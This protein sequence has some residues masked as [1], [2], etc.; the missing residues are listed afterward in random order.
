LQQTA[1]LW[2][3]GLDNRTDTNQASLPFIATVLQF[4]LQHL[5]IRGEISD[6]RTSDMKTSEKN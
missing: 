5:K 4:I 1:K 6:K 3:T 2:K